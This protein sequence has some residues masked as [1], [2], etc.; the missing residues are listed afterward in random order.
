MGTIIRRRRK[1]GSIGHTAQIRIKKDGKVVHTETQTFDRES[2]ARLWMA[3]REEALA[4]PGALVKKEDPTLA[5]VINT[6]LAD[7][8]K[9]HG[10]TKDQVLRT[11][12][13]SWLGQLRCSEIK[14]TTI[15]RYLQELE[16]QPQTRGN[17]LS[18]LSAVFKVARPAWGYPLDVAAVEDAR[19]V[20]D[21]LGLIARSRSRTRRPTLAELEKLLAH[22]S[23]YERKRS[24][25][26]P[27]TQLILFSIFST[28]RQEETCRILAEDVN[29]QQSQVIVRDMKNP[30][31]KI[32]NDVH[33]TLTPEAL[34]LI[35]ARGV[36][37]GRIWP[38]NAESVSSSFTRAC[39]F[40][41]I[42]DLH[43]HDLRHEGVSRLFEMGWTIP[44]VA[45]VSGHR[46]WKGL[47][48]YTHVKQ[49]GDKY[50]GWQSRLK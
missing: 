34:Q 42:E 20:A 47:Q 50:E 6:Y 35:K 37:K 14:S 49:T 36:T 7:K 8:L 15:I 29:E 43:F 10:V 11:I 33:T 23:V 38:Y 13:N 1:D 5:G 18:H 17:Y 40:L 2:P 21:K 32:G 27:M 19:V 9:P 41:G 45:M 31:E 3:Q 30:G 26:I 39:K 44:H 46:S 25:S 22:Y 28:R 12:K 4:K 24:D 48:R 16:S